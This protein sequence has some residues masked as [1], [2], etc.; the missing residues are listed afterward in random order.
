[1]IG[2]CIGTS[3]TLRYS[4]QMYRDNLLLSALPL[5][6]VQSWHSELERVQLECGY[7]L[8][9]CDVPL[10]YVYFPTTAIASILCL[11]EDR[12]STDIAVVGKEGL[13]GI[14][15]LLG[16]ECTSSRSV[17]QS[18]GHAY[19]IKADRLRA[20]IDRSN[21]VLDL[22]LRYTQAFISQ[23]SQTAVCN[24]FHSLDKR[25]C[26][27]LLMNHD[28]SSANHFAIKTADSLNKICT[29]DA[30]VDD[31]AK[32]LHK[33]GVICFSENSVSILDRARLEK[34]ACECYAQVKQEY[35]RLLPLAR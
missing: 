6:I 26:R 17:V 4:T 11:L 32:A 25:L 31:T 34:M 7:V 8:Y 23:M 24:R 18:A 1:M 33:A 2:N 20:E 30:G 9:E 28:C 10:R 15:V 27:W 3:A 14:A 12:S 35:E 21:N 5:D 13:V 19:R 22:L 16:G 29:L